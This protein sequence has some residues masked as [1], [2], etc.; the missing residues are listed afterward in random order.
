[1]QA[2][3]TNPRRALHGVHSLLSIALLIALLFTTAARS[4]QDDTQKP[5][6]PAPSRR[7]PDLPVLGY[8]TPWNTLGTQLVEDH[9]QK[10]DIVCPVWY[11][12]HAV[13][14]QEGYEVRGGPPND[15][16][17]A[18]YKRLQ[19]PSSAS[20]DGAELKP[21][22]VAP[23]FILDG[24]TE[25]DFR[26]L[27]FNETRWHL[28]AGAIAGVV[29]DMAFDGVV[30]ESGATHLL[31]QVL[32]PLADAL[33]R[34]GRLL[35]VVTQPIRSTGDKFGGADAAGAQAAAMIESAND[36]LLQALPRLALVADFFSVMTYDMTG[37]GG[38]E[39][40]R[41]GIAP[42]SKMAEVAAT[43]N[44][45]EPGPNT[46]AGWV[47]E[48]LVMFIE[49][50]DPAGGARQQQQQQQQFEPN[51]ELQ[52]AS[53]K[54]LMGAPLYGY[55]YPILY[56]N[57]ATGKIVRPTPVDPSPHHAMMTGPAAPRPR[58]RLPEG[59][60]PIL[61]SGGEPVT[62]REIADVMREHGPEV[63]RAEPAGE[64]Y[65]DYEAR[66]GAGW[67]RVFV[68]TVES[69][70]GVLG[71]I[72]EV[73]DDD[74]VYTFGGAGVALWEVGQSTDELLASL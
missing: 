64:Y 56:A 37:P 27:V 3:T 25:V 39:L 33:H 24:W 21:V 45:R 18:W 19:Q 1:M 6:N 48:N 5:I 11:T 35:V 20:P 53:R 65:F 2:A 58:H 23:R 9:R 17:A 72:Q 36:L 46:S 50:T 60:T 26:D 40:S 30:F 13:G 74:L 28:L 43:G 66:A 31:A 22:Q 62:A 67:W 38:R 54:F 52:Q 32:A 41:E 51:L 7:Y 29:D 15:D 63:L 73:V 71:T 59:A 69:L 14:Q 34:D 68:P 42:G 49:A 44:V 12:V 4:E 10:F 16:D 55:K 70:G 47:R 8:V 57:K 61:Q